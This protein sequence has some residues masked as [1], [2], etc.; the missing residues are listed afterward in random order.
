[1]IAERNDNGSVTLTCRTA[2]EGPVVWKLNDEDVDFEHHYESDGK[3]LIVSEIDAPL[4]GEYSCWRGGKK[5]S[6]TFLLQEAEEQR[7]DREHKGKDRLHATFNELML[8]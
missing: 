5:L 7:S 6:S 8:K 2:S 3:N 1:M 4:L